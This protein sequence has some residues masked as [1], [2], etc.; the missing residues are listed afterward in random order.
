[1]LNCFS[2][3]IFKIFSFREAY[4]NNL[5]PKILL[6]VEIIIIL[7]LILISIVSIGVKR[8]LLLSKLIQ[9]S[10]RRRGLYKKG[11]ENLYDHNH[12]FKPP[13]HYSRPCNA[14]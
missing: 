3:A 14:Y 2:H 7:I 9:A 1:M 12:Y 11:K 4:G 10:R 5:G 8:N 13:N 6:I